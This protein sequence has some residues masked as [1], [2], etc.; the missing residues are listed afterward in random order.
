ML[1]NIDI[2]IL[3]SEHEVTA[4][5][6]DKECDANTVD[7]VFTAHNME[8]KPKYNF[9]YWQDELKDDG[10]NIVLAYRIQLS[11]GDFCEMTP[12]GLHTLGKDGKLTIFIQGIE[13][14]QPDTPH[15]IAVMYQRA[16]GTEFINF[17][18][19]HSVSLRYDSCT[20]LLVTNY[21]SH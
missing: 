7:S 18:D 5:K 10:E 8:G 16:D 21:H 15:T 11:Q 17:Q 1:K 2:N 14:P 9:N 12:I 3:F 20:T 6:R 19:I 13:Y 4:T